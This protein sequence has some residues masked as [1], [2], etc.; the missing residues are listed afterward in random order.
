MTEKTITNNEKTVK[1]NK[2]I[3]TKKVEGS[4]ITINNADTIENKNTFNLKLLGK[5]FGQ[6]LKEKKDSEFI[7]FDITTEVTYDL[8][9]IG[10]KG[11]IFAEQKQ[12]VEKLIKERWLL[13]TADDYDMAEHIIS[14]LV[15]NIPD[16]EQY[17][18]RE[19]PPSSARFRQQ[20]ENTDK[21]LYTIKS[22]IENNH[23]I[24]KTN[25][26]VSNLTGGRHTEF[27]E[28]LTT[29]AKI[30]NMFGRLTNTLRSGN[31]FW[32]IAVPSSIKNRHFKNSYFENR[33]CWRPNLLNT[34][35]HHYHAED[36]IDES[37]LKVQ[38]ENELWGPLPNAIAYIQYCM[39]ENSF[40]E[41][42][43]KHQNKEQEPH[44][45][46]NPFT[47]LIA[48]ASALHPL[49]RT[50]LFILCHLPSLPPGFFEDVLRILLSNIQ[51]KLLKN[52]PK[53]TNNDSLSKD[54]NTAWQATPQVQSPNR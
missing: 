41:A 50:I 2:G 53:T 45:T 54:D 24:P 9:G 6:V 47:Q 7:D 22:F 29:F 8:S 49:Y 23:L 51:L 39:E 15:T 33:Y 26:I 16:S 52:E 3:D 28:F 4:D 35:I 10:S 13:L 44:L 11:F 43:L 12:F 34:L 48:K 18:F 25:V 36:E 30:E 32:L 31:K 1:N 37:E 38:I 20:E 27:N 42:Y 14:S 40:L 46:E 5:E 19:F 21:S 17:G